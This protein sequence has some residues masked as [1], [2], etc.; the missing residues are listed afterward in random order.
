MQLEAAAGGLLECQGEAP[1][2]KAAEGGRSEGPLGFGAEV[3]VK[4]QPATGRLCK[5]EGAH[6]LATHPWAKAGVA[7]V[8]AGCGRVGGSRVARRQA[9]NLLCVCAGCVWAV[10]VRDPSETHAGN[11][12]SRVRHGRGGC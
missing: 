6:A 3:V 8:H 7:A 4:T 11:G 9:S 1:A 5:R 12:W 10:R 2:A